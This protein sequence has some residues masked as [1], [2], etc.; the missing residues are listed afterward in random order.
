M[1]T[2]GWALCARDP[3]T[4]R[5]ACQ[6][7]WIG[8]GQTAHRS[9]AGGRGYTAPQPPMKQ[10]LAEAVAEG[11]AAKSEEEQ[12]QTPTTSHDACH[13]KAIRAFSGLHEHTALASRR[14]RAFHF[15][16]NMKDANMPM[17][18]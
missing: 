16:P 6:D 14:A 9:S 11:A 7:C 15:L 17:W 18:I 5:Q 2:L 4:L 8:G 13:P 1:P 3:V 12:I 10:S